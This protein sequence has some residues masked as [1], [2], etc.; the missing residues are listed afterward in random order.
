MEEEGSARHNGAQG[1]FNNNT[2]TL[3]GPQGLTGLANQAQVISPPLSPFNM[4]QTSPANTTKPKLKK[5][6]QASLKKGRV[7]LAMQ[8]KEN[9]PRRGIEMEKSGG[10][11][12]GSMMDVE[13]TEKTGKR[14]ARSPL[15]IISGTMENVKRY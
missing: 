12:I 3:L 6:N 9:N 10:L 7:G 2:V 15:K 4:G 13:Q 14:R 11:G 1:E 5:H 8:R